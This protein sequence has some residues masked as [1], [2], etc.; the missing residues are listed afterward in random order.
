MPE[1]TLSPSQGSKNSATDVIQS[2]STFDCYDLVKKAL[3]CIQYNTEAHLPECR[4]LSSLHLTVYDGRGGGMVEEPNHMIA[5]K[6]GP[7][8]I[9]QYS[10]VR[11]LHMYNAAHEPWVGVLLGQTE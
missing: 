2:L 3:F 9:I 1:L 5:R 11:N 7:L 4:P 6:T 10:L 8:S